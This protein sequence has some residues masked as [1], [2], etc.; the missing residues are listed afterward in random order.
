MTEKTK[1]HILVT[2]GDGFVGKTL[3]KELINRDFPVRFSSRQDK[4]SFLDAEYINIA[5]I[6]EQTN[7]LKAL[8]KI[9]VVIH[10]AARVHIMHDN[11]IDSLAEFRKVNV[12]GTLR[13][14]SQAASAG[15][16]RFI[17]ISS[18][19]VNGEKTLN[20][21]PFK[22]SDIPN[23][24][25]AYGI[26]KFE[27]EQG[28]LEIAQQ[29]GMEVVIIRP[30]LIYGPGVKANFASLAN[31]VKHSLPLPLGAIHNKRSFIYVGNLVDCI[32][33]CVEHPAAANQ[34]FLVSDGQDLS[35]TEL[36][37]AC[38]KALNKKVWLIPLPQLLIERMAALLGKKNIAQRLCGNLQV[39]ISRARQLMD[40]TPPI[41]VTDGLKA[42]F[43]NK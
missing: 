7:W 31:I 10:L 20:G 27:A 1:A 15:V 26:S 33:K 6:N 16:K 5:D 24:Q 42:T 29:T 4:K 35:T 34:L 22:E 9:N 3:L 41:S 25:D 14:A 12:D 18:V 36:L 23:P 40:W 2:G 38:G 28:L 43:E 17:F 39:D 8:E 30:P 32:V 11:A 21:I 37:K 13:F 19:K